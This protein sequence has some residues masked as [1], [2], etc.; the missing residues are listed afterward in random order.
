MILE[1]VRQHIYQGKEVKTEFMS[2]VHEEIIAKTVCAFLNSHGGTVVC[3]VTEDGQLPGIDGAS[4]RVQPIHS[5]LS[6]HITPKALFTVSVDTQ[7]GKTTISIDVPEGKDRPYIFSG[8]VYVREESKTC[9]ADAATLR[10]MV[11]SMSVVAE[12]WE[13]RPS[14]AMEESD[15][16][17]D[18][19]R[20]TVQQATESG[21][22]AFADN[23]DDIAI[24]KALA[25]YTAKG[26]TQAADVLFAKNPALRHPQTRVRV[27]RFASDKG[28]DAYLDDRSLHGALLTVLE[29]AFDIILQHVRWE[30]QFQPGDIRRK[31]RPEYPFDAL[32]EGLVNAFAH[33]DY[34]GFSGGVSVGIYPDRIKIWNSGHF[35]EGLKPD[36]LDRDHSSLP[37]NPDIAHVLYMN[38]LMERIGRGGRLIIDACQNHGLPPPKWVDQ[39]DGVTLTIFGRAG[40]QAE[41]IVPPV[42]F[43]SWLESLL[44]RTGTLEIRGIGS[45]LGRQQEAGKYP[46]EQLYTPLRSQGGL[47]DQQTQTREEQKSVSLAK[48]LPKHRRLLIEGQPGAGKTTFLKLVA[49]MLTKDLLKIVH[50]EGGSWQEQHLGMQDA[51]RYPLFLRLSELALLLAVDQKPVP[52]DDH[53]RLLDLLAGSPNAAT[54]VAWHNHWDNLLQEGRAIVLLDGLDEVAD[55]GLR[56]RVILIVHDAVRNWKNCPIIVTSRPFG[57]GQMKGLDFQHVRIDPFGDDEISTFIDRWSAALHTPFDPGRISPVAANHQEILL[58]AIMNK[59]AIRELAANPV[60]LTCLCVVHWHEGKLPEGLARVYQAVMRWLLAA[61]SEM[62][63]KAGYEDHF[64]KKAFSALALAMMLGNKNKKQVLFNPQEGAEAVETQVQRHFPDK[65]SKP[66]RV[67][68]GR[69]WLA[70]ECLGSGIVEEVGE[71]R[72]KFW[73]LTFQ[74]YL[75]AQALAWQ[76]D[77]DK[78]GED[79]WPLIQDKL[80]D[81]QWQETVALLPGTLF[82]EGGDL[83]VDALLRRVLALLPSTTRR[84]VDNLLSRVPGMRIK[85]PLVMDAGIAG[86]MGR[87]LEPMSAYQYKPPE[88]IQSTYTQVRDRALDVFTLKGAKQVPIHTR[89]DAAEALGWAGDPRLQTLHLIEV[90][91]TG[92]WSLGKY[93]VTVAE[94]QAFVDQDGYQEQRW[95]DAAGWQQREQEE[96]KSPGGWDSQSLHPNRPV[97]DVSWFEAM[98]YCRWLSD[99]E[100]RL[101]RLSDEALWE[102]AATSSKRKYPWGDAQPT[103]ELANF[104]KNVGFPTPVGLYPAGNGPYGHCDLVGNVWEWQRNVYY[105]EDNVAKDAPI[106]QVITDN[107][108]LVMRGGCW[109]NSAKSLH[110]N[111]RVKIR[112]RISDEDRFSSAG[113]RVSAAS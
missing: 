94:Y 29:Q 41:P 38:R 70:F 98:A 16:D 34:A 57:V 36:D 4:D 78:P 50:P 52:A 40:H 84:G 20:R 105:E 24:L 33:R 37:T 66:E 54:D 42:A 76:G 85:N 81:P 45:G 109:A 7:D 110:L 102:K 83:R 71:Q 90:P 101:I 59:P 47:D 30:S 63:K 68:L 13:R 22:F 23:A 32:R 58:Q 28:G 60:M 10:D 31:E 39:S 14:M 88:E 25:V 65:S 92:G 6:K 73:H 104:G 11:Q 43:A 82:D 19:I 46:I 9:M 74:E 67:E 77:G 80:D 75:A 79:Y 21:R 99:R 3:G 27:I 17:Q 97:T 111:N 61:R 56:K 107:D 44:D 2:E 15:L 48:L 113:F 35:P 64:A 93:P 86:T 8:A 5:Y 87:L 96:W 53:R 69:Q 89:I 49:A 18:E 72:L 55:E 108:K 95:W 91:E 26:F 100:G 51:A 106:D 103:P 112:A 62:R 12:R 1:P